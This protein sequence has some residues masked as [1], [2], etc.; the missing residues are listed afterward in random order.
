M[1]RLVLELR[2]CACSTPVASLEPHPTLLR[3]SGA[4]S[5]T[6][7]PSSRCRHPQPRMAGAAGPH[8][9]VVTVLPSSVEPHTLV[10]ETYAGFLGLRARR[11]EPLTGT[12]C[13]DLFPTRQAELL[14]SR[15]DSIFSDVP[16]P[17]LPK[18][19]IPST[20]RSHPHCPRW[21]L[22]NASWAST[23]H[24]RLSHRASASDMRSPVGIFQKARPV[25]P[26][27]SLQ[28]PGPH[29]AH[30][31]LQLERFP[32][33]PTCSPNLNPRAS[34]C[35]EY[36]PPLREAHSRDASAQGPPLYREE[37]TTATAT[38]SPSQLIP[39]P[40]WPGR[41]MSRID[42]HASLDEALADGRA[43]TRPSR[44]SKQSARC[45]ATNRSLPCRA[46]KRTFSRKKGPV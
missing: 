38:A 40:D 30:R 39:R 11:S 46:V 10:H 33:T 4:R 19:G 36:T 43:V 8:S 41:L 9:P 2:A 26:R 13:R 31:L 18:P 15:Q 22:V 16:P 14:E 17:L 28:A 42:A 27:Y 5:S 12:P 21:R 23:D 35:V 32:N 24:E 7:A 25:R 44:I 29:A 34:P 6:D 3:G 1:N 20:D 37:T 45:A